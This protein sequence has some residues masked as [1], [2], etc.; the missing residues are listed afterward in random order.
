MTW[1]DRLKSVLMGQAFELENADRGQLIKDL[2]KIWSDIYT[3]I[4][5]HQG[6]STEV[7]RFSATSQLEKWQIE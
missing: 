5:L 7:L 4:G 3:W 2:H 1:L 6:L